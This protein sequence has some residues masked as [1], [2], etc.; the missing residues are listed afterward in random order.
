MRRPVAVLIATVAAMA[1]AACSRGRVEDAGPQAAR[2]FAVGNFS[3]VEVA[4]PYDVRITTGGKSAVMATGP[5]NVLAQ[6]VVEVDGDTLHIHPEKSN[7]F[8]GVS[9]GRH[10]PV[11]VEV[12]AQM[13]SGAAI[14][15]SGDIAID[16]VAGD[17]F[18]AAIA[19]SGSLS[20]GTVDL[21]T[22]T[23]SISGSGGVRGQ[24]KAAKAKYSIAGSGDIAL[25]DIRTE[26]LEVT[27]AGSGDVA[28]HASGA[29]KITIMGSGDVSVIGGAKCDTHKMGSGDI[30]C[31]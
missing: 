29:A 17:S 11:V 20:L 16:K 4:G 23:V 27:V 6:M 8:A 13:L 30:R 1:L 26:N 2:N 31:S 14:A 3:K 5:E 9:F 10:G 7:R 22:L 24:G 21:K 12:S 18:D 28:A 19:G 25:Q 15:G